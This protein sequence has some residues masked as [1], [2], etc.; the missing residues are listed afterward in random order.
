MKR[1]PKEDKA[2]LYI[3]VII[4]LTVII[5]LLASQIGVQI[6]KENSFVL[7]FSKQ[8]EIEK[9]EKEKRELLAGKQQLQAAL[10]DALLGSTSEEAKASAD[11]KK[12][13]KPQN[14]NAKNSNPQKINASFD[15][16]KV[17]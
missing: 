12:T 17:R 15:K 3:T 6:Q 5:I 2:G 14:K 11:E 8:E 9:L 1:I 7:D 4:H 16:Y 13:E 10:E